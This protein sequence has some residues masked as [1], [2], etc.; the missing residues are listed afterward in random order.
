MISRVFV[1]VWSLVMCLASIVLYYM[2]LNLGWV[3]GFMGIAIGSA[4][5][6]LAY[7]IYTQRLGPKCATAAAWLGMIGAVI[8]WFVVAAGQGSVDIGTLGSLVAQLF[9]GLVAIILSWVICTIGCLV[10][11]SNFD[12]SGFKDSQAKFLGEDA[13]KEDK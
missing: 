5:V 10:F 2:G 7:C 1:I 6:P 11:P 9:G 3:Y 12:W 13:S 4:V 8:V